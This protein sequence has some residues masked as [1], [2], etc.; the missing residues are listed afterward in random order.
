MKPKGENYLDIES[1]IDAV[2]E[3]EHAARTEEARAVVRARVIEEERLARA[4]EEDLKIRLARA[5]FLERAQAAHGPACVQYKTA[6]DAFRE[7]RIRL[8]ALDTILG[9]GGFGIFQL[10][11]ELRHSCAAPDEDDL[12]NHM[13]AAVD[14]MRRTLGG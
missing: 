11:V 12:N 9:R 5:A 10:G 13:R 3:Q 4:A 14:S 1:K 8:Q 6:L 2:L 7:A